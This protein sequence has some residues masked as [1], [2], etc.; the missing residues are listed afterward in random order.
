MTSSAILRLFLHLGGVEQRGDNC[1]RAYADGYA[2]F[3]Q[4]LPTFFARAIIII[5]AHTGH[6]MASRAA[7]EAE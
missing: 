1:R 5:V 3:A 7:L 6:F 4:F 2:C